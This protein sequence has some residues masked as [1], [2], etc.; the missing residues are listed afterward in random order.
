M[1]SPSMTFTKRKMEKFI[2]DLTKCKKDLPPWI[3]KRILKIPA[4]TGQHFYDF[5]VIEKIL[6]KNFHKRLLDKKK[7][8]GHVVLHP[9]LPVG[10]SIKELPKKAKLIPMEI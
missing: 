9:E 5:D 6:P 10:F 1:K 2:L 7:K 8:H 4:Q 3:D